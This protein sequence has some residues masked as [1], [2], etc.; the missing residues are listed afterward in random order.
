MTVKEFGVLCCLKTPGL[1]KDIRRQTR[2]LYSHQA[3]KEGGV[4]EGGW[5]G[6]G[7]IV[8]AIHIQRVYIGGPAFSFNSQNAVVRPEAPAPKCAV[9]I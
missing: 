5:G 1:R 3:V 2:Q 7:G 4:G 9:N 6:N 8:R